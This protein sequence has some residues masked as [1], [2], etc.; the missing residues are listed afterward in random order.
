MDFSRSLSH[1]FDLIPIVNVIS[2]AELVY[3]T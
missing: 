2:E 1:I 3:K